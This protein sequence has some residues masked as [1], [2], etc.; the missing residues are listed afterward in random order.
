MANNN[1][2]IFTFK[3]VSRKTHEKDEVSIFASTITAVKMV[4]TEAKFE[5]KAIIYT[6]FGQ[7][8]TLYYNFQKLTEEQYLNFSNALLRL[9]STMEQDFD[10]QLVIDNLQ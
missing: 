7:S 3:E 4:K 2:I 9:I 6:N 8:F 10:T 1:N 5:R